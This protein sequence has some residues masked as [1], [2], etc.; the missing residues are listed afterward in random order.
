MTLGNTMNSEDYR[1][2]AAQESALARAAVSNAS[3]AQPKERLVT[4]TEI[5]T[6]DARSGVWAMASPKHTR[7]A[8]DARQH[9]QV[10]ACAT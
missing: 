7:P 5:T 10:W 9:A 4:V 2:V 1:H 8:D 3:K 6:R